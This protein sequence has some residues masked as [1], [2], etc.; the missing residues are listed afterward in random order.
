MIN[1]ELTRLIEKKQRAFE[2]QQLALEK[3]KK[4]KEENRRLRKQ[5]MDAK[6]KELSYDVKVL[7]KITKA[8]KLDIRKKEDQNL[9]SGLLYWAQN[10]RDTENASFVDYVQRLGADFND[11]YWY[12]KENTED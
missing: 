12:K 9:I 7:I 5:I 10:N 8:L 2:K 4:N 1:D 11:K 6:R 3:I